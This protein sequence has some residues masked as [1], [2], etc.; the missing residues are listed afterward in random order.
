MPQQ[1]IL[2]QHP[3]RIAPVNQQVWT[4]WTMLLWFINTVYDQFA[5]KF[6]VGGAIVPAGTTSVTVVHNLGVPQYAV[7]LTPYGAPAPGGTD[8]W[9]LG[10]SAG[11]GYWVSN[12][13]STQFVINL[14]NP[15]PTGG[16]SFDWMVKAV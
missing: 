10:S 8:L 13:T 6:L 1:T 12:K 7:I 4:V 5:G 16:T 2:P 14:A 11:S 3:A 9:G 15:A